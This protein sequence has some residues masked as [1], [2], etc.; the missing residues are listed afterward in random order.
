MTFPTMLDYLLDQQESLSKRVNSITTAI[1]H[2]SSLVTEVKINHARAS[3][4]S[5]FLVGNQS[6]EQFTYQE[7]NQSITYAEHAIRKLTDL[8][9][10]VK[11]RIEMTDKIFDAIPDSEF[12]IPLIPRKRKECPST[13]SHVTQHQK[14]E[15]SDP[16][17]YPQKVSTNH[18]G[19][20]SIQPIINSNQYCELSSNVFKQSIDPHYNRSECE[21]QSGD[22]SMECYTLATGSPSQQIGSKVRNVKH[23][24][25]TGAMTQWDPFQKDEEINYLEAG[26]I[27]F[28]NE[29]SEIILNQME[30]Q[31]FRDNEAIIQILF[32]NPFRYRRS[33]DQ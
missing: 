19:L 29:N 20:D 15:F 21:S 17:S 10:S 33:S 32:D 26:D 12:F 13:P 28:N 22:I 24:N 3:A 2:I 25:A 30:L 27:Q 1:S 31:K 7:H 11:N 23:K 9:N 5:N 8:L 6:R 4:S 14:R 16:V 18:V